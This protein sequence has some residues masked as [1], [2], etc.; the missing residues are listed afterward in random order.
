MLSDSKA[1]LVIRV[2]YMEPKFEPEICIFKHFFHG[3]FLCETRWHE[4]MRRTAMR[5]NAVCM[6]GLS[7]PQVGVWGYSPKEFF[8]NISSQK[9]ILGQF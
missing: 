1:L 4:A 8:A 6:A 7:L 3:K 2:S 5:P 9:G